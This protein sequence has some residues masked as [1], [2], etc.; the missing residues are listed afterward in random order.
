MV[1][2]DGKPRKAHAPMIEVRFNLQIK[3]VEI[4]F[5]RE[6]SVVHVDLTFR[7][8]DRDDAWG[9][10]RSTLKLG[11][12]GAMDIPLA[13]LI[14]DTLIMAIKHEVDEGLLIDGVRV[15]DP[16]DPDRRLED[17]IDESKEAARG[18]F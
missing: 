6:E 10:K 16:H 9:H 15:H 2:V 12:S 4:T 1:M 17:E 14:R 3:A 11:A 5:D 7:G 13:I 18:P 8:P